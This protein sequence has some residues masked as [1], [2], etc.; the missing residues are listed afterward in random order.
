M[1]EGEVLGAGALG[2]FWRE[3][4]GFSG[5]LTR[6]ALTKAGGAKCRCRSQ[7]GSQGLAGAEPAHVLCCYGNLVALPPS[8]SPLP[9]AVPTSPCRPG[10]PALFLCH[11]AGETEVHG[12]PPGLQPGLAAPHPHPQLSDL[13]CQR[14]QPRSGLLCCYGRH[15]SGGGGRADR[16]AAPVPLVTA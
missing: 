3:Q 14:A 1:E 12:G 13:F 4:S 5:D 11:R 7:G 9:V 15:L 16:T 2:C 10:R 8:A 6:S